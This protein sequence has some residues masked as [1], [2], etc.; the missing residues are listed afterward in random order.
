MRGIVDDVAMRDLLVVCWDE[1]TNVSGFGCRMT[2]G[3]CS[4]LRVYQAQAT[5]W[6]KS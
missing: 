5:N 1:S 3:R 4:Q 2:F 6:R